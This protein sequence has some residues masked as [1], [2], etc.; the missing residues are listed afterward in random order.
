MIA[1]KTD[2]KEEH[3]QRFDGNII[4]TTHSRCCQHL[5]YSSFFISFVLNPTENHGALL[6]KCHRGDVSMLL[7]GR[8]VF[9]CSKLNCFKLL[10][11]ASIPASKRVHVFSGVYLPLHD[12]KPRGKSDIYLAVEIRQYERML[13]VKMVQTYPSQNNVMCT[14]VQHSV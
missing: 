12:T 11:N 4:H 1:G 10:T 14:L 9:P 7:L 8:H 5:L 3:R 2:L 13:Y 6:G